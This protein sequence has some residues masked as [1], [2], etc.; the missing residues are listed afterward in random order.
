MVLP[1]DTNDVWDTAESSLIFR[2][3]E[4]THALTYTPLTKTCLVFDLLLVHLHLKRPSR[5]KSEQ[6]T[7]LSF[8]APIHSLILCPVTALWPQMIC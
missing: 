1:L 8:A 6:L 4:Q 3:E 2:F 7:C 5:P